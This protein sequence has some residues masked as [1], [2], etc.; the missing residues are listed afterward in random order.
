MIS[1]YQHEMVF[2]PII[3]KK[4][5][6]HMFIVVNIFKFFGQDCIKYPHTDGYQINRSRKKHLM[7]CSGNTVLKKGKGNK[8]MKNM[9]GYY[10]FNHQQSSQR[11]VFDV[12]VGD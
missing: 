7:F 11:L 2:L 3:Q 1:T 12:F 9:P 5:L 6:A 4:N 8:N 10:R